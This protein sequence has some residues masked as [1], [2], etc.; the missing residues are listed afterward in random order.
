VQRGGNVDL[1]ETIP[2]EP[3]DIEQLMKR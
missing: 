2:I 3:D 1:M